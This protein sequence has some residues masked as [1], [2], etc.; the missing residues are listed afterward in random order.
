MAKVG[1]PI[2]QTDLR[3]CG[4]CQKGVMHTGLPLFYRVTVQRYGIDAGAVQR[5]HG[6]EMV[7]GNATIANV[8]GPNEDL[9]K[10]ISELTDLFICEHCATESTMVAVLAESESLP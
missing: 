2:K 7:V 10:P 5:Q 4:R 9:A 3:K 6:L 8:L 1:E